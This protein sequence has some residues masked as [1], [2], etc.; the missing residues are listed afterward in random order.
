MLEILLELV[1]KLIAPATFP[2]LSCVGW[3]PGLHNESFYVSDDGT[4]VVIIAGA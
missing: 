1:I 3:I 4:A 2:A